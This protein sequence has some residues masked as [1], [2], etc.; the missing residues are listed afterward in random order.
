MI[1][2][3]IKNDTEMAHL[4]VAHQAID[5][6]LEKYGCRKYHSSTTVSIRYR[7]VSY[8]V[9]VRLNK[10]SITAR[11]LGKPYRPKFFNEGQYAARA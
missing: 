4:V 3:I 11:L 2:R 1:E 9:E 5:Y 6:Y 7:N 10:E 8:S